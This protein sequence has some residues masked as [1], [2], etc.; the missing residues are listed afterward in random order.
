MGSNLKNYCVT[1][2]LVLSAFLFGCKTVEPYTQEPPSLDTIPRFESYNSGIDNIEKPNM[3]NFIFATLNQD[4]TYK[5]IPDNSLETPTHI[6]MTQEDFANIEALVDLTI[7][8]KG[9]IK[10]QEELINTNVDMLNGYLDRLKM[11]RELT[12]QYYY[13][14]NET[15][16]TLRRERRDHVIDNIINRATLVVTI[17]GGVAIAA[18]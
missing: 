8:Y 17:I 10:G 15:A 6:V 13:L 3:P 7:T 1:A 2:V 16:S 4:G 14:W 11:E 12:R 5:I 9:V 18:L